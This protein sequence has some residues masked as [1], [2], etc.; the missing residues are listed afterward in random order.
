[1]ET[2]ILLARNVFPNYKIRFFTYLFS[3]KVKCFMWRLSK[4]GQGGLRKE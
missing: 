1:M 2:C 4:S 3:G